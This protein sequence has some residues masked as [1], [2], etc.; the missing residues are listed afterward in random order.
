MRHMVF[1]IGFL[2]ASVGTL[3]WSDTPPEAAPPA[4]PQQ[5]PSALSFQLSCGTDAA[6]QPTFREFLAETERLA[7]GH[8]W[9][10]ILDR[11]H[12]GHRAAQVDDMGMGEAQY[13][14]ELFEMHGP[15]N[16]I[17][18]GQITW[19]HL[20]K[21]QSLTFKGCEPGDDYYHSFPYGEAV[22]V[23]GKVLTFKLFVLHKKGRFWLGGGL[24]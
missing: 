21:I 18:E 19:E 24:G 6:L 11:A 12:P 17:G 10:A 22:L 20:N 3:A 1:L 16:S 5:T 8:Q 13:V 7:E 9:R 14:A 15:D 4:G 23:G 2:I